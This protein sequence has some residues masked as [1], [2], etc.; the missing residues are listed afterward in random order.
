MAIESLFG[1][2]P[3]EVKELRRRQSEEQIAA[4][5]KEFGVFA[6]LYRAG[7]RFGERG[8]EATKALFGIQDP[9]MEKATMIQGV[10]GKYADKDMTSPEVLGQMAQ[11]FAGMGATKEAMVLAQQARDAMMKQEQIDLQRESVEVSRERVAVELANASRQ[12]RLT[13]AQ[14]R[15]ID[16]RIKN[17]S[18][19]NYK[20]ELQKDPI[21]NT[22]G[23][24][25]IDKNNPEKFKIIPFTA[26]GTEAA[27]PDNSPAGQAAAALKK[28]QQSQRAAAQAQSGQ[29]VQEVDPFSG[30]VTYRKGKPAKLTQE[31]KDEMTLR[32]QQEYN[33]SGKIPQRILD[34]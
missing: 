4:S 16:N 21:G 30:E 10:L 5:G 12:N 19:D 29:D 3:A 15:E 11:E 27:K 28:R 14:I 17:T 22:I 13:D 34:M 24:I 6:P 26:S 23:V 7:L 25:A 1:L 9:L 20:F 2:G 32:E 33:R 18:G 31:Q 8:S